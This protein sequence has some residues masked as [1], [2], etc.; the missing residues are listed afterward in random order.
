MKMGGGGFW[1]FRKWIEKR[2]FVGRNERFRQVPCRTWD[3]GV[4]R[5]FEIRTT[6]TNDDLEDPLKTRSKES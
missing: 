6:H 4:E 3:L 2:R 5:F 1:G